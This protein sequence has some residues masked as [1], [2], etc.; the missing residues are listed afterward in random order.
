MPI[1]CALSL[2][3]FYTCWKLNMTGINDRVPPILSPVTYQSAF[4]MRRTQFS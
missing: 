2:L 3:M 4:S 1:E